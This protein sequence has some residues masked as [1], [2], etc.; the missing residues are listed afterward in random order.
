[1]KFQPA[2]VSSSSY[3]TK[4]ELGMTLPES[5]PVSVILESKAS[6]S[7]WVDQ[8][9]Q[10]VAVTISSSSNRSKIPSLIH[11]TKETSQYLCSGFRV[12]L[13]KDECESY[14]HNL[15]SPTPRCYVIA[16]LEAGEAPEPFLITMSFDEAHAYLE[17]DDE[18]YDVD[19]PPEL[20]RWTELFL[21][22]HFAPEKRIK[23]KR[24]DW[25]QGSGDKMP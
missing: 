1:M 20:Y 22:T 6:E 4:F 18:V 9:W 13:H 7:Q 11:S 16:H 10:A 25:K 17:G 8:V 14:Y 21:L 5:L 3:Q 15:S 19:I 24:D 12:S 2:I 23:R